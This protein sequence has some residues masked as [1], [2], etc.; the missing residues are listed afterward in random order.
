MSADL[1][2]V[3]RARERADKARSAF[4]EAIRDAHTAG[5][6]ARTIAPAAGLSHQRVWQLLQQRS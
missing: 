2:R 5:H 1:R 4:E 3:Q 6:S